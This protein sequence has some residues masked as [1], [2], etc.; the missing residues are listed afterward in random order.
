MLTTENQIAD[1]LEKM[2]AYVEAVELEKRAAIKT[3][4]GHMMSVVREKLS[5]ASGEAIDEKLISKLSDA[6]PEVFAAIEKL[7]SAKNDELGGPSSRPANGTPTNKDEAV[8]VAGDRLIGW[9]TS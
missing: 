6:D 7:A 5:A 3:E 8:K 4:R 2:A 9:A 1:I